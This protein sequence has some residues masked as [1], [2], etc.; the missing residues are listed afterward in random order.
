MSYMDHLV[1]LRLLYVRHGSFGSAEVV[2]CETW[3]IW[4]G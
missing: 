1:Q 3:I 2:V 4:F